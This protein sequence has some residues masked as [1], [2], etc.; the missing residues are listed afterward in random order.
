[1]VKDGEGDFGTWDFPD[2]WCP[3]HEPKPWAALVSGLKM[4]AMRETM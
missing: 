3:E 1:M 2:F 4:A